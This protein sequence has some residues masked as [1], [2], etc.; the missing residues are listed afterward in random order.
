M[1]KSYKLI[2]LTLLSSIVLFSCKN[3]NNS[4]SNEFEQGSFNNSSEI[5]ESLED[6]DSSSTNKDSSSSDNSSSNNDSSILEDTS[7]GSD[8]STP[9]YVTLNTPTLSLDENSG[10]VTISE[11]ADASFYRYYINGGEY[12]TTNSNTYH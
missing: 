11:D 1:K 7:S 2:Y 12:Q 3:N 4:S 9:S 8:S 6:S 10:V 5:S